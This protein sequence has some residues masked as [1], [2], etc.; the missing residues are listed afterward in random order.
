MVAD[1]GTAKA[2]RIAFTTGEL[3]RDLRMSGTPEVDLRVSLDTP[4]SN[5]TALL[6]DFGEDTRVDWRRGQGITT[7]AEEDC[8]GDSTADDDA[9]YKKVAT[10]LATRPLEVVARGW[11]DAQN[12]DSLSESSPLTPGTYAQ[13]KWKTLPQEYVFKK[14][15]RIGLVIAGTDSNY[16]GERATGTTV[17]V[18]LHKSRVEIPLV[19]GVGHALNGGDIP[20]D[21]GTWHGPQQID[22]PVPDNKLY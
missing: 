8:H 3:P 4:A 9:C 20:K 17:T 22:L 7:L 5:L 14:G 2:G 10:N 15:H 21:K 18:D 19:L 1:V 11:I 16:S 13:V 6:V 12:R